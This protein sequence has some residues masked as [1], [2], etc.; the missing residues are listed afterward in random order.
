MKK[1]EKTWLSKKEFEEI[2]KT[3]E[4]L[5]CVVKS[6]YRKNMKT[7]KFGDIVLSENQNETS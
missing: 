3:A 2:K 6:K 7:I 5:G 1:K 4:I